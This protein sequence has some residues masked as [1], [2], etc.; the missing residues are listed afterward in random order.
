M[1]Q[2]QTKKQSHKTAK[3]K[4]EG[5]NRLGS[6]KH[7]RLVELLCEQKQKQKQAHNA[8]GDSKK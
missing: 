8:R 7:T 6:S 1:D 3:D 5:S 4:R 2:P